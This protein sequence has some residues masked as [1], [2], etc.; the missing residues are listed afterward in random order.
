MLATDYS[1]LLNVLM[2]QVVWS[3]E[4]PGDRERFLRETGHVP[5]VNGDE[6]RS[7]RVRIRTPCLLIPETGLPAFPRARVPMGIYTAD[8]S[9]DGVSFI[10]SVPF[11]PEET[12]RVLLPMFW[13]EAT[14]VRSRR[15]G[16]RC[17]QN[18]AVLIRKNAPD[19]D[20]FTGV[21]LHQAAAIA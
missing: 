17:H 6:R 7:P 12:V 10:A 15:L 19:L 5:S 9:R 13:L 21:V 4:F 20:A 3:V 11:L 14:I 16:L 1:E 18:C 8:L 2:Q